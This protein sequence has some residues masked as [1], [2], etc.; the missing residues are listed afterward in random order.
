LWFASTG[1][2]YTPWCLTISFINPHDIQDFW[3]GTE[4][5]TYNKLFDNQDTFLSKHYY[6]MND[7][8]A[9][10][11]VIPWDANPVKNPTSYDY[12]AVPRNWESAQQISA[13]K[14]STQAVFRLAHEFGHGG[15]SDDP[16]QTG[17]TIEALPRSS[18]GIAKAPYRYWERALDCYTELMSIVDQRIGEV[19]DAIPAAQT[20][21]TLVIF[22]SDHGDFAGAHGFLS[23][24]TGTLYD[25]AY[26]I[27]LIVAD[28]SHRFARDVEVPRDGLTSSVDILPLVVSLGHN[29]SS[30]W[31][32]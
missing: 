21:N 12:P 27:P 9:R 5:R 11:P 1:A 4:F 31:Q 20:N 2:G 28:P 8:I 10:S 16:G 6:S 24:K 7:R 14:P 15:A 13:N 19:L 26:H 3:A 29:G 18:F 30:V 32:I 22:T 25:E 17:F 23:G